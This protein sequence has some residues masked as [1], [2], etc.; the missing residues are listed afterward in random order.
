MMDSDEFA[1]EPEEDEEPLPAAF[2]PI[3]EDDDL[4]DDLLNE[5]S[6]EKPVSPSEDLPNDFPSSF[7]A[8]DDLDDPDEL[9]DS[10]I[11]ES[12]DKPESFEEVQQT[13]AL[14]SAP[15]LEENDPDEV[16]QQ[17]A[18]V[19]ETF[20]SFDDFDEFDEFDEDPLPAAF[21][22][23]NDDEPEPAPAAIPSVSAGSGDEP[24]RTWDSF[25]YKH[26]VW[27]GRFAPAF[28]T[29]TG[30]LSLLVNIIL[31]VFLIL[32]SQELFAL[33]SLISEQLIG[34]LYDN[35]VKM[36]MAVID[37]TV[38]VET[39]IPVN[40]TI[41]VND[42]IPVVFDLPLNQETTVVLTS[43]V[44]I[45][46]TVV[47]LN[48]VPV[49]TNIT[50]PSGTVLPVA[51]NLTVPVSQTIPIVLDVPISIDVPVT[52]KIPVSIPLKDTDLAEPF[53]GLQD[54]LAPYNSLLVDAPDSW[55]E[56]ACD[57]GVLLC[58]FFG[59]R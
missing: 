38:T 25:P 59:G 23:M 28:W 16:P 54:T 5:L 14:D 57:A 48:G 12:L 8:F 32:L 45:N 41:A 9:S 47:F 26:W 49:P 10:A 40:D 1:Q 58:I 39:T 4:L 55:T 34:G 52:L 31:I 50:L 2:S 17:Q 19:L 30:A 51:L 22:D 24:P 43:D 27:Q 46:N 36:E 33:K 56:A 42:E 21:A 3:E 13:E 6:E 20:A 53:I 7:E 11:S 44:P 37:T 18:P 35:F 29:I 15:D